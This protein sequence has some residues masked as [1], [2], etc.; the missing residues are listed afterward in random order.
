[1]TYLCIDLETGSNKV[2]GRV[3]NPWY[4]NI[5]AIGVKQFD[6]PEP[7]SLYKAPFEFI[8][9]QFLEESPIQ[10]I[11][12]HN[13]KYDLLYLWESEELQIWLKDGGKIWD[14]QLAEYILTGQQTKY[15]ALRELAV[16]K[17]GCKEREKLMEPYWE[18]D[19]DTND[20]PEELVLQDV[21][22]DVLDTEQI[23]LQQVKKAEE[24]GMLPLIQLQMDALLATTEMEYNGVFVNQDILEINRLDLEV[25]LNITKVKTYEIIKQHWLK[26]IEFNL[27]SSQH[28]S[29]L[30][31]GGELNSE[32]VEPICDDAG[33]FIEFKTGQ[34]KGQIKTHKVKKAILIKGLGAIPQG[35]WAIKK[36]GFYS[37]KDEV[38]Q[39]LKTDSNK[40]V[41]DLADLILEIRGLTKQL[42]TY[43]N[44]VKELIYTDS[45][46][47][48]SFIHVE[49]DTSRLSSRNPNIQNQPKSFES[50][51]KQHFTS[52]YEEGKIIELDYQQLEIVVQAQLSGD[53]NYMNDVFN[54]VDFHCKRLAL[55]EHVPYEFVAGKIQEKDSAW[56]QKRSKIKAFSFARAYGA[57][58]AKI[59]EQTGMDVDEIKELI[60]LEEKEYPQLVRYNN[61]LMDYVK[62]TAKGTNVGYYCSPT[63]RR[64]YFKMR[65]TQEWLQKK[66]IMESFTPTQIKN[67]IVQGTATGDINLI[68]L[69]IFWRTKAQFKREKYL[70][71]N[72]VHDSTIVD[73][74][75]EFID[76][77]I[78]D[79]KE[80]FTQ[81]T[82]MMQ[83]YFN[84][85]WILPVKVDIKTGSSWY[86]CGL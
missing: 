65:E 86:E 9:H 16:I 23:Y 7:L 82:E 36:D 75:P 35:Q 53:M 78:T 38:L 17:Y 22:N 1:M 62:Y 5:V 54:N 81:V 46:V 57:G 71:I 4:N 26:M 80:V 68:M 48:P 84:Y 10:C 2:H 69:G 8:Y 67:Y 60:A 72:T 21:T 31:F 64:Y 11:V 18:K 40:S 49:T 39:V 27:D 43:Y 85:E 70:L 50:K 58:A 52:R 34:R 45:L 55:K 42:S 66:G 76:E 59:S 24:L 13:I 41:S 19:I 77:A 25:Q 15:S 73:C 44:N 32:M 20:I 63:S 33:N 74:R 14:T 51:V 61:L 83:E 37:T 3:G 6:M 47:H 56:V 12:G 29:L 30:F 28:L 79:L